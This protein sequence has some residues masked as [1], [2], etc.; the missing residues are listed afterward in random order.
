MSLTALRLP[1]I[2]ISGVFLPIESLPFQL[3]VIS[4]L[5]PLT[6]LVD[7]LGEAMVAPSI[8]FAVDIMALLTWIAVL[9]T[10]A[11][12]VLKRTTRT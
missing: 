3:R 8:V 6:Y 5:T 2:F 12:V 4:Y 10:L 1:M 11:I 9:Q 7:A